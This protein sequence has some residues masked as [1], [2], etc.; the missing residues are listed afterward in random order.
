MNHS[1]IEDPSSISL[2][3]QSNIDILDRSYYCKNSGR[4]YM[5]KNDFP[6]NHGNPIISK[7]TALEMFLQNKLPFA[8]LE[9]IQMP[10]KNQF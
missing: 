9:T 3:N 5:E 1:F 6:I 10:R 4:Q 8:T 2:L 7:Q